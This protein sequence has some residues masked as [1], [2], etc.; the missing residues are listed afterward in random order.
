MIALNCP[1]I[2]FD[3]E[4]L[5][6]AACPPDEKRELFPLVDFILEMSAQAH[7]DGILVIERLLS[8]MKPP[9]LRDG[10]QLAVDGTDP[11]I[12]GWK[13]YYGTLADGATGKALL[14]KLLVSEGVLG[15]QQGLLPFE[16]AE[17]VTSYFGGDLLDEV[18]QR[19][20]IGRGELQSRLNE[21]IAA[22][23]DGPAREPGTLL[24]KYFTRM[25]PVQI[26]R[27]TRNAQ[28]W[29][30]DKHDV[31]IAIAFASNATRKKILENMPLRQALTIVDHYY[32][33]QSLD[34][35]PPP[36]LDA[37]RVPEW[38]ERENADAVKAQTRIVTL[39]ERLRETG[40]LVLPKS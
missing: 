28:F 21:K 6:K 8:E 20:H 15:I 31:G 17:L 1:G 25:N 23:P 30:Y 4:T 14:E 18:E 39:I 12:I 16:I 22:M 35:A 3:A 19:F 34:P 10:M 32:F 29:N 9:L 26:E 27:L 5:A 24:E 36:W 2:D 40:E 7:K 11:E 13:L 33:M 37:E 38:T